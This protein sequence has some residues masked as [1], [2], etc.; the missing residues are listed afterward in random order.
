[1]MDQ[2]KNKRLSNNY[3][4]YYPN[5]ELKFLRINFC[6]LFIFIC[7]FGFNIKGQ[8]EYKLIVFEGSD[9]C[10]NCQRLEKNILM[11]NIFLEQLEKLSIQIE[12]IDFPQRKKLPV[13]TKNYNNMIA[14][15]YNFD[16]TFPTI[17]ISRTDALIFQKIIYSN[18]SVEELMSEIKS[19]SANLK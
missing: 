2:T 9:W 8:A 1:M 5:K 12:K 11:D 3:E 15:K 17:I 18:Q 4:K 7:S 6:F 13:E 19:K 14:E 10:S 16:G